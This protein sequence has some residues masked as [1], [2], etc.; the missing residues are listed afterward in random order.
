MCSFINGHRQACSLARSLSLS[1][2]LGRVTRLAASFP[3]NTGAALELI[4]NDDDDV[5]DSKG[6]ALVKAVN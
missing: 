4:I 2:S 3:M 1:L 6:S 5:D